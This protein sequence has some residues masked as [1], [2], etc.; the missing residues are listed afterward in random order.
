MVYFFP[1]LT[2]PSRNEEQ[3][4]WTSLRNVANPLFCAFHQSTSTYALLVSIS[5]LLSKLASDTPLL[6]LSLLLTNNFFSFKICCLQY[7]HSY[8]TLFGVA[9]CNQLRL[10]HLA[11][12]LDLSEGESSE[13]SGPFAPKIAANFFANF[14]AY[15]TT[16]SPLQSLTSSAYC[17]RFWL[18]IIGTPYATRIKVYQLASYL[19]KSSTLPSPSPFPLSMSA[20]PPPP[21]RLDRSVKP[22]LPYSSTAPPTNETF[23][24]KSKRKGAAWG[25]TAALKGITWSDKIGTKVNGWAEGYGFGELQL[26]SS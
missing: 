4:D 15:F 6:P 3:Q 13:L 9:Q 8:R 26:I 1:F 24:E 18:R 21:K 22:N 20:H 7:F 23:K 5:S 25:N 11:L 16:L 14:S 2:D 17:K 10:P 12:P 19:I